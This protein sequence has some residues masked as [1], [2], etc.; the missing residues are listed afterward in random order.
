MLTRELYLPA[1]GEDKALWIT[2]SSLDGG[3]T[4]E[5]ILRSS[6]ESDA[7]L[8]WERR[9]SLD[10]GRSWSPRE[11]IGDVVQRLPGGGLVTYPCGSQYEPVLGIRYERRMRRLW[12]GN[13]PFTFHWG[14]HEH[15]FN[16]HTSVVEYDSTGAG[17]EKLLRYEEG[18]DFDV[19]NPFNPE[20]CRTNQAYLGVGLAFAADGAAYYP[21][22]CHP[23]DRSSHN[24]GGIVLMRRDP[25][26]G[27]WSASNQVFLRPDQSSRGL[28]EPDAAVL[29]DGRVL[30]IARGSNTETVPGRKWMTV[31]TD[32]GRS[33]EPAQELGY[34]DGGSFYS[35]SS[36][37][38]L[39][40]SS[41][42]G[43]L[44]WL[45]NIVPEPPDGN[46][47]RYPLLVGEIDESQLAVRRDSLATIDER[48]EDEPEAV[49][50]SN[51]SVI[52]NSQSQDIEIYLTRIGEHADHF[53]QGAVYRYTFS[54]GN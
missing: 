30:I 40:R 8:N 11:P 53:W 33:L 49:Q 6:S 9:T 47:P 1:A 38:T 36:I 54:P 5:E 45:A 52:E 20:F 32:G 46:G 21:L 50:L 7:Y 51:F 29:A 28:L 26:S 17:R 44:Y 24:Q 23:R 4:R 31:S 14:D 19:E 48:Q 18:P 39:I 25:S 12:P 43:R 15:P 10:S 22:V 2:V 41:R 42:N 27:E 3:L 37:H 34:D 13:E 16:D 35:P